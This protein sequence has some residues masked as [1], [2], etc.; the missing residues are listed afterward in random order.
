MRGSTVADLTSSP[1]THVGVVSAPH[2]T[3]AAIHMLM[4]P[5]CVLPVCLSGGF[6]GCS[7]AAWVHTLDS[8][9]SLPFQASRAETATERRPLPHF[10]PLVLSQCIL[11]EPAQFSSRTLAVKECGKCSFGASCLC[12]MGKLPAGGWSVNDHILLTHSIPLF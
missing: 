2:T 6:L 7:S 9:A 5:F 11:V 4:P 8:R 12:H 10:C 1:R 3:T